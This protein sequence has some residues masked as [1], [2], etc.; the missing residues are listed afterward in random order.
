MPSIARHSLSCL[1]TL[2]VHVYETGELYA[3]YQLVS[4]E[5]PQQLPAIFENRDQLALQ[6]RELGL[7]NEAALVT[8][9]NA[10]SDLEFQVVLSP[11]LRH[12]LGFDGPAEI[13]N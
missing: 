6:L 9:S 2:L 4:G 10:E 11:E 5:I 8:L 1:V 12:S 3:R 13:I 7:L